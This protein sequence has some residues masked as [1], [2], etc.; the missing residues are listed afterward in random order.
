MPILNFLKLV[1]VTDFGGRSRWVETRGNVATILATTEPRMR[2]RLLDPRELD[3]QG[4]PWEGPRYHFRRLL[5][6]AVVWSGPASVG[7]LPAGADRRGAVCPFCR[8]R[9]L[10]WDEYCLACD[11]S[12]RDLSI[13]CIREQERPR[14]QGPAPDL[15]GGCRG[16][17]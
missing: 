5:G 15:D 16:K 8:G 4:R 13:P 12:G 9:A 11:A 10:D 17:I 14:S 3:R 2:E 6:E 7:E 1:R